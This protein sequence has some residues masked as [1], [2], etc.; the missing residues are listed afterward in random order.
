MSELR[1]RRSMLGRSAAAAAAMALLT[2]TSCSADQEGNGSDGTV[3]LTVNLTTAAPEQQDAWDRVIESFEDAHPDIT[4]NAIVTPDQNWSKLRVQVQNDTAG[5][6]TQLADDD[7]YALAPA[8]L[9][10]NDLIGEEITEAEVDPIAWETFRIGDVV[11]MMTPVF[12]PT[13]LVYNKAMFQAAGIE[14]PMTWEDTWTWDEFVDALRRLT[15]DG[16]GDGTPEQWGMAIS[17]SIATL[18]SY[19][20]GGSGPYNGDLTECRMAAPDIVD[21]YQS[22]ADLRLVDPVI[23]PDLESADTRSLF[24]EGKAAI[25]GGGGGLEASLISPDID[26]GL[27]PIPEWKEQAVTTV[28]T[29]PIGVLKSSEH[30]EEAK[31]F[32]AHLFEEQSQA[33]FF[34]NGLGLPVAQSGA[35]YAQD[36]LAEFVDN[37]QLHWES[38]DH[39]V[40]LYTLT[41]LGPQWTELFIRTGAREVFSGQREAAEMLRS[42]CET[43]NSVIEDTGPFA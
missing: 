40:D 41:P 6:I 5:D 24:N 29:N 32:M 31:L 38:L 10:L 23:A 20:N 30:P 43:M 42:Q 36:Q 26:W 14:A 39:A 8:F 2:A 3:E 12:R 19:S 37:P 17:F 16:D 1:S 25:A 18:F 21:I 11:R 33:A 4:I 28:F 27:L 35:E 15:V 22:F 7:A 13:T 34:D 9:E